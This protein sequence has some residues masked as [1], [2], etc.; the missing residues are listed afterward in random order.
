MT[1]FSPDGSLGLRPTTMF[2]GAHQFAPFQTCRTAQLLAVFEIESSN[3]EGALCRL[4]PRQCRWVGI[5]FEAA[6]GVNVVTT[7]RAPFAVLDESLDFELLFLH[8]KHDPAA[9]HSFVKMVRKVQ[10]G[11]RRGPSARPPMFASH[12]NTQA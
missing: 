8:F 4:V 11:H 1:H 9:S 2:R 10:P 5:G 6:A 7:A 3:V 12:S